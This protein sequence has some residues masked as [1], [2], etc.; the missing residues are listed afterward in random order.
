MKVPSRVDGSIYGAILS[1]RPSSSTFPALPNGAGVRLPWAMLPAW[2]SDGVRR[3]CS[4]CAYTISQKFSRPRLLTTSPVRPTGAQPVQAVAS[5]PPLIRRKISAADQRLPDTRARGPP[6]VKKEDLL[7]LVEGG[8]EDTVEDHLEF[9]RDPYLRGYAPS[10]GPKVEVSNRKEDTQFPSY[11]DLENLN[12]GVEE[13]LKRLRTTVLWRLRYRHSN[14]TDPEN[15]YQIYMKLPEPRMRHLHFRLRHNLLRVFGETRKT[16]KSMLRY[17]ALVADVKNCGLRLSQAEWN[18]AMSFASRY[19]GKSTET[20]VES[21]LMLWK[22]M[23][24]EAGV[25]ANSVTFGILFD[26]ASKAGN[27]TLAEMLYQVMEKRGWEFNRYH[28]VSLIHF[29]GLKMDSD[30]VRAAYRDMV[31][32]GE[33]IDTVVLN[34]VISG[35]L[36]SGEEDSAERVY[37]R[38]KAFH[39]RSVKLP[40]R[41]YFKNTVITKVLMMLSKVSRK[42]PE[43][44]GT[45]QAVSP[46]VPD[47]HT[48]RILV[49]HFAVKLGDLGRVAQYL[50][51][52]SF[53]NVPLHGSIFL[54]LF[55][56]FSTHGGYSGSDWSEQRLSSVWSA[57]LQ[58]LDKDAA[59]LYINTWMVVWALRAFHK[60]G[61]KEMVLEAYDALSS[62]WDPQQMDTEFAADFLYKLLKQ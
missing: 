40:D 11:T 30:G 12:D 1:S 29:F 57:F 48:Y 17:F 13:T 8:G 10:D 37:Q 42:H 50:D 55:K 61:S 59:G 9:F 34:C 62:R 39:L 41:D 4:R 31:E 56:G 23:E 28:H 25:E 26:V 6:A 44:Q 35:F 32:A 21:A 3:L 46:L 53:F 58:A 51:E 54:A 36:R 5:S 19:V 60:C 20:E 15:I 2:R 52:M 22:E 33:I 27:F 49:N 14:E 38:M 24:R 45:L 7:A 16:P 18:A 43:L 47:L